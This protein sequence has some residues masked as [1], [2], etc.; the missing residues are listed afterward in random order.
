MRDLI[1]RLLF[2]DGDSRGEV[3]KTAEKIYYVYCLTSS[4][5][6]FISLDLYSKY[7]HSC[8]FLQTSMTSSIVLTPLFNSP[9]AI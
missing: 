6:G 8:F 7:T 9:N 5:D 4:G 3:G 2:T 1:V